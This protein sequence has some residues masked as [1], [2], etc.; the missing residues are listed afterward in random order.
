MFYLNFHTHDPGRPSLDASE[1][2]HRLLRMLT[3][4]TTQIPDAMGER[5]ALWRA[6]LSRRRAVVIPDDAGGH[7]EIWP[8]LRAAGRCLILITTR[9]SLPDLEGAR[10]LT[11]DVLPD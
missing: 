1:A 11:L 4:P 8:L 10:A 3:S 9:R 7:D 5:A 6:Q 2:L